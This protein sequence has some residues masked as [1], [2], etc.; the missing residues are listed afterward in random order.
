MLGKSDERA[1]RLRR[2]TGLHL[3]NSVVS[4]SERCLRVQGESL[5]HLGTRIEFHGVGLN[6]PTVNE[7]DDEAAVQAFLD[8]AA[9]VHSRRR[10]PEPSDAAS[11][12]RRRRQHHRGFQRPSLGAGWTVGVQ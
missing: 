4:G 8:A 1:I 3:Y 7:G 9:N 5:N 11:A 12:I 6:C 2:G 10:R